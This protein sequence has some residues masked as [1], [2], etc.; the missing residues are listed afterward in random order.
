MRLLSGW[1][2]VLWFMQDTASHG[3]HRRQQCS[4]TKDI[5]LLIL[6]CP[7]SKHVFCRLQASTRNC[8]HLTTESVQGT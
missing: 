7:S 4:C 8:Y 5:I 6:V 3:K 2:P 1:H